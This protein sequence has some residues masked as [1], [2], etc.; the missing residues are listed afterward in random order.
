M[1]AHFHARGGADRA[2]APAGPRGRTPAARLAAVDCA[3]SRLLGDPEAPP[4]SDPLETLVLTIL[5]QNTND[6]NRDRAWEA[7]RARFPRWE[8]VVAAPAAEVAAAIRP[9][10][11]AAQ[12]ADRIRGLLRW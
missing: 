8:G 12:K 6:R 4:P 5:S 7:L 2:P 11:L 3:L 9:G 10:G 1:T